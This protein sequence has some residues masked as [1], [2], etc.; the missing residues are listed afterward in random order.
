VEVTLLTGGPG[1]NLPPYSAY[2]NTHIISFVR[3]VDSVAVIVVVVEAIPD[4]E[5]SRTG[6][7]VMTVSP[8]WLPHMTN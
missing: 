3:D 6:G 7:V 2:A 5:P 8:S 1:L 4:A